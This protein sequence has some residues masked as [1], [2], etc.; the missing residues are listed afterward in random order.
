[1]QSRRH[2]PGRA[3]VAYHAARALAL[4]IWHAR[5]EPTANLAG[6]RS[7]GAL[8]RAAAERTVL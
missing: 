2:C 7:L 6:R 3:A 1:L 8:E 5:R 4:T